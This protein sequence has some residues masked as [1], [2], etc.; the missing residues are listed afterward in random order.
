MTDANES[1]NVRA[2]RAIR[3]R[4]P[5]ENHGA[6]WELFRTGRGYINES[7][8]VVGGL[9]SAEARDLLTEGL[10]EEE[11]VA[12]GCVYIAVMALHGFPIGSG[13]V[14]QMS[15]GAVRTVRRCLND[16]DAGTV[17][18]AARRTSAALAAFVESEIVR[19]G[20]LPCREWN[21]DRR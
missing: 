7:P 2:F 16:E 8:Y 1:E 20:S 3:L 19:W 6:R 4:Q 10:V 15:Q 11:I 12:K 21:W 13:V 9:H 18:Q 5:P 17:L 14:A